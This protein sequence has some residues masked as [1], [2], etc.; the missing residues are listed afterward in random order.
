MALKRTLF[1]P[2]FD[3]QPCSQ[4]STSQ[5]D[6]SMSCSLVSSLVRTPA[7]KLRRGNL[8]RPAKKTGLVLKVKLPN[9]ANRSLGKKSKATGPQFVLKPEVCLKKTSTASQRE[10]SESNAGHGSDFVGMKDVF[11]FS[12][13]EK[14]PKGEKEKIKMAVLRNISRMLAENNHIRQR[15]VSLSQVNCS[16]T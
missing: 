7:P 15:L 1:V 8:Q 12:Q 10:E 11:A 16:H 4:L 13:E 2:R 5:R 6:E 3:S 14:Q 9:A